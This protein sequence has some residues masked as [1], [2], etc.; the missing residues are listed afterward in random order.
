MRVE[1]PE[2]VNGLAV[3]AEQLQQALTL[4]GLPA[5]GYKYV[6]TNVENCMLLVPTTRRRRSKQSGNSSEQGLS[7]IQQAYMELCSGRIVK[8]LKEAEKVVQEKGQQVNLLMQQITA[9][10]RELTLARDKLVHFQRYSK[11]VGE[12]WAKELDRLLE[13][14]DVKGLDVFEGGIRVFTNT[15]Y[16]PYGGRRYCIGE[17]RFEIYLGGEVT[18]TNLRNRGRD[19]GYPHPHISGSKACFGNIGPS[20][21][22]LI[23]EFEFVAAAFLIIEFLKSYNE[24]GSPYRPISNW[25]EVDG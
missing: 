9:S 24:E 18:F 19:S 12:H 7:R 8:E 23:G 14:P 20:V 22:K 3:P 13:H 2:L 11:E 1:E 21:A 5:D 6:Y 4:L 15:I 25:E 10:Q 17:F 16:I